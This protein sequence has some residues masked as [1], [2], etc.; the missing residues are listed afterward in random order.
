MRRKNKNNQNEFSKRSNLVVDR[1]IHKF[2]SLL[3]RVKGKKN[4]SIDKN[5]ILKNY[6]HYRFFMKLIKLKYYYF[7]FK[8][9][10]LNNVYYI[11]SSLMCKKTYELDNLLMDYLLS[12]GN[13]VF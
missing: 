2:V 7:F 10:Q 5:L 3:Y 6:Y 8:K 9:F 4:T 13:E 11:P 1:K 12:V